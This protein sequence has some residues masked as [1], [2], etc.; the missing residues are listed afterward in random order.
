MSKDGDLKLSH[1]PIYLLTDDGYCLNS[2]TILPTDLS[3]I[4]P[5]QV[6]NTSMKPSK[7]CDIWSA[8]LS[9][10]KIIKPTC[11]LPDNPNRIAFCDNAQKV[12]DLLVGIVDETD[13]QR[14]A[15]WTQFFL[16]CL[17]PN[18]RLRGTLSEL[19]TILQQFTR[20]EIID[21]QSQC[22]QQ[23]NEEQILDIAEIYH[24]WRLSIGRNYESKQRQD[25]YPPIFKVPYLIV[26]EKQSAPENEPKLSSHYYL[27]YNS[28]DN[29]TISIDLIMKD[30]IEDNSVLPIVIKEANFAYQYGRILLFK[31]LLVSGS[32]HRELLISES[33][34]DIP[35]YYRAEV[36]AKLLG[37]DK[38]A[39]ALLYASIDKTAPVATE[40]QISVD[41][42]RCHQYNELMASPQGHH[43]LARILK[44]WLNH[45]SQDYVYWQGLDSLASP[46]LLLNFHNEALAFAC[47]NAFIHKYLRGMFRQINQSNVQQYLAMF[48]KL[49]DY[50]DSAMS[51]HLK[52]LGFIPNLYAIPWFFTMFTH[53][54][55]LHKILHIWDCLMLGDER[56]PLCIGL[57]ILNQL[58]SELM[59]FNFNDCLGIFSDLPEIDIERC[60]KDANHFYYTTPDKLINLFDISPE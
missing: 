54:L 36:W 25:D 13:S 14:S 58:K 28:S 33:S 45:N 46:F 3:F 41:I 40:R 57:A 12:L 31:R 15:I 29:H 48:S 32:E 23:S 38:E 42:P 34:I 30:Q 47:F 22:S 39:S 24:L 11:K 59:E 53:V 44:A 21:N 8:G 19:S 6:E 18:P 60:I 51:E 1:W 27:D 35:P 52:N 37:V 9:L 7:C 16:R 26:G 4:A 17:E 50:H 10:L 49:L 5:E 43:K 2:K 20:I 55:P 56:F